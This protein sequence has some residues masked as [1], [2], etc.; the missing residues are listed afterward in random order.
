MNNI[1][2]YKMN[3]QFTIVDA[4]FMYGMGFY[5]YQNE[6]KKFYPLID[7]LTA[8]NQDLCDSDEPVIIYFDTENIYFQKPDIT[9]DNKYQ[10]IKYTPLTEKKETLDDVNT[11]G[12]TRIVGKPRG[13]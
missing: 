1:K 11:K 6:T 7:S 8:N 4:G 2:E 3:D 5:V 10:W 9:T 13:A 12:L